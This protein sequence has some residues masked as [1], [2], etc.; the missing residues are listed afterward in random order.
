ME[1]IMPVTKK[2]ASESNTANDSIDKQ[3]AW[4]RQHK[5]HAPELMAFAE[6]QLN[7]CQ[8]LREQHAEMESVLQKLRK[9]FD[10]LCAPEWHPVTITYVDRRDELRVEVAG[11]SVG[12]LTVAV[13]PDVPLNKVRV[14]MCGLLTKQRNCLISVNGKLADFSAVGRFERRVGRR[15]AMARLD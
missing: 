14:G 10:S 11:R 1:S 5:E 8:S 9:E 4:I 12:R 6:S 15:R 3:L 7:E 13:H 2:S